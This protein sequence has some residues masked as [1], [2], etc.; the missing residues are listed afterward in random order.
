MALSQETRRICATG[1]PVTV[2][3]THATNTEVN[4]IN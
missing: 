4:A 2:S 1:M 3:H